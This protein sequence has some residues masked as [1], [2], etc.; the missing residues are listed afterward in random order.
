VV[1]VL[2]AICFLL[3]G[4]ASAQTNEIE[5]M[6]HGTV[7]NAVS[8]EPIGRALVHSTDNRFA[9]LTNADGHFEF[10]IPKMAKP[11]VTEHDVF[12]FGP[13]GHQDGASVWLV[14]VKPGFLDDPNRTTQ[15]AAL[16]DRDITI[17]LWPEAVIKGRVTVSGGQPAVS[18]DVQILSTQIS[19]GIAHWQ[20]GASTRTSSDGEFRFAELPAGG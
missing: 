20:P 3:V 18:V 9:T 17:A 4:A 12:V 8:H 2:L 15:I 6:V 19:E 5:V 16:P 11:A 7:V 14:A 1:T 13:R 10:T